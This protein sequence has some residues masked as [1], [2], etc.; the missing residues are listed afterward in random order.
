MD[1]SQRNLLRITKIGFLFQ[2]PAI[3]NAYSPELQLCVHPYSTHQNTVF[4]RELKMILRI[5]QNCSP[6][7]HWKPS[8]KTLQLASENRMMFNERPN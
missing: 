7:I 4:C 2:I 8:E 6:Q 3:L 1:Q 5:I